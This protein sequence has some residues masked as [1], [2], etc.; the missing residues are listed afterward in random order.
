MH[1]RKS[2]LV[3]TNINEILKEQFSICAHYEKSGGR[4]KNYCDTAGDLIME[5]FNNNF[6]INVDSMTKYL[7]ELF[8]VL[9]NRWGDYDY[10]YDCLH[11][12]SDKIKKVLNIIFER[13]PHIFD[14]LI[15]II[16]RMLLYPAYDSCYIHLNTNPDYKVPQTHIKP[17]LTRLSSNYSENDKNDD[18]V[19]FIIK[20][21]ALTKNN[22]MDMCSCK[23]HH[24]TNYVASII[25]KS[26]EE[27]DSDIMH[28][29][30]LNLP[31]TKQIIH[32]LLLKGIKITDS[33]VNDA[34]IYGSCESLE[35]VFNLVKETG[36]LVIT[37]EHFKTLI[38]CK[39]FM[40]AEKAT[41]QVEIHKD[42]LCKLNNN[43]EEFIKK[44]QCIYTIPKMTLLIDN[45][46]VLD[47]D[48]VLLS[49]KHKREIPQ[50]EKF[51][52]VFDENFLKLCQE[53]QF[54][55]KYNF[56]CVSTELYELQTLCLAKNVPKTR[57]LLKKYPSLIPNGVCMVNACRIKNNEKMIELL[58]GA[59]GIVDKECL[60][61]YNN[62]AQD[63]FMNALINNFIANN[64]ITIKPKK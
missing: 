64:D 26:E 13:M 36:P 5:A 42:V 46:F 49:V 3:Y 53:H 11:H 43:Y 52:V 35:F 10:G 45:G 6:E 21:I 22:I 28:M 37:K 51:G 15:K 17:F 30:I 31:Y 9:G 16:P 39:I 32:S 56:K 4:Y 24:L 14:K 58:V 25:D 62:L 1:Y 50:L 33:D 18:L 27:F 54:Y 59:G 7:L 61:A 41:R 8:K 60:I 29:A 48:D 2:K 20:N 38:T 12:N 40:D 55:P 47:K 44:E 34:L 19:K 23:N 57:A 63:K